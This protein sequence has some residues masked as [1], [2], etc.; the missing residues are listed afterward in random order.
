MTDTRKVLFVCTGNTCRSPM[1]EAICKNLLA[2]KLECSIES[3]EA[4]GFQVESAGIASGG[5]AATEPAR[6]MMASMGLSIDQHR[7][8]QL[9]AKAVEQADLI[10]ALAH[11]HKEVIRSHFPEAMDRVHLIHETGISDP[12]GGS[13]EV[14]RRCAEEIEQ[15]LKSHWI[16]GIISK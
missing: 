10:I 12:I 8:Q 4:H 13:L 14:Y 1:A 9:S 7:S 2:S 5:G 3:L 15:A 11:S 6:Q 16:E